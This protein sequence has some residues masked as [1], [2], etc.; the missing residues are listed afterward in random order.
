[1]IAIFMKSV[2]FKLQFYYNKSDNMDAV[3]LLQHKYGNSVAIFM[4]FAISTIAT[5]LT[6]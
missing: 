6:I 1:M 4:M 2:I 5:K 3:F